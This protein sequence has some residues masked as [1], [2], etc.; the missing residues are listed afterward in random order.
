MK[1]AKCARQKDHFM[2]LTVKWETLAR[3]ALAKLKFANAL[4]LMIGSLNLMLAKVSNGLN[5]NKLLAYGYLCISAVCI[6][7]ETQKK[8]DLHV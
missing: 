7:A 4:N 1:V 8:K 2:Q 6:H 3:L 5:S